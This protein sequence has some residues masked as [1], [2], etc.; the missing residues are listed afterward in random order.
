[1]QNCFNVFYFELI[2][3]GN[4]CDAYEVA[5][6]YKND[7]KAKSFLVKYESAI[8]PSRSGILTLMVRGGTVCPHFF[9]KA[10]SPRK[11]VW[12]FKIS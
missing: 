9:L 4:T 8:N 7:L 10:F 3:Q 6:K 5:I 1:M 11:R 2:F 12:M